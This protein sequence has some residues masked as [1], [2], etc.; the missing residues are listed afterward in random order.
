MKPH[1]S[2]ILTA[3]AA[4][5]LTICFNAAALCADFTPDKDISVV[6]REDGSGTRGAF[7]E[8][9]AITVKTPAGGKKDMTTKEAVI[10]NK[11]DVMMLNIAN[12]P[13]AIGYISLGS[14]NSSIKAL[15]IDGV[16]A[17]PENVRDGSYPIVRPFVIATKGEPTGLANDFISFILSGDGQK[18][19]AGAYI[20]VKDD[21][22]P[23]AGGKRSGKITVAG[24][25]SVAPVMEKLK[26]AYIARNSG[27]VI[28]IQMSDSTAGMSGAMNGT[29]DIGMSSR[30]LKDSEKAKLRETVIAHDGIAVIVN[31]ANPLTNVSSGQV[32]SIF[33]GAV[34]K[35]SEVK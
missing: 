5:V 9:F 12:D 15:E 25:S 3:S 10:A 23:Y 1:I 19:V 14:L 8:L 18:V 26:E 31:N 17:A 34:V 11:T 22:P 32:K 27:A 4:L 33:T 6:S 28:E 35:W 20:P 7:V 13:Y 16:K 2:A 24:S 30:N 21:A 29:C